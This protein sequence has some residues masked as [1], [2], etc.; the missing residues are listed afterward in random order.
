MINYMDKFRLNNKVAIVCGGLGLIGKEVSIS[1]AQAGAKVL[2]LDIN[3]ELGEKFQQNCFENNLN[4]TFLK[5][6]VS[7]FGSYDNYF[8]DLINKF[9]SVDTFVNATYPRTKDWGKKLEEVEIKSWQENINIHLNSYCLLTRT[10]AELMKK[11][12]MGGCIINY[13]STYGVVGPDF[14]VYEGTDMTNQGE[15]AAIKGGIINFSRYVASYYGK[16]NIRVNSICPGG[17]LANQNE[18]FLKNY[19]KRTPLRRMANVDE[20]ASATL[21][22][23][24]D[25]A[26]YITGTTFM[27]DGGWTS[28]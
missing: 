2:V 8:S 5:F 13:G 10:I 22:L 9:G 16:Y 6:D 23:A 3:I 12:Q 14:N 27:V 17:V 7:D 28:I 4:I 18:T 25:A 20:I 19:N 21:F 26:S 11:N 24:S 1:L 15:Y